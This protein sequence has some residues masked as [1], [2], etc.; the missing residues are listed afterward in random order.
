MNNKLEHGSFFIWFFLEFSI[1]HF[2]IFC[3][4]FHLVR[5]LQIFHLTRTQNQRFLKISVD[6]RENELV[7]EIIH[8][9]FHMFLLVNYC[10]KNNGN[11]LPHNFIHLKEDCIDE[12]ETK[13]GVSHS[14]VLE[15]INIPPKGLNEKC[16]SAH[17]SENSI[18]SERKLTNII[19]TL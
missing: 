12:N 7:Q 2:I 16:N 8:N 19:K 1:N 11:E 15:K 10:Q 18:H 17:Y 4:V 6:F 5:P 3:N 14:G 9:Q 13:E